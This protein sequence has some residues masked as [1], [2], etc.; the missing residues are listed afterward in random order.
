MFCP[1]CGNE[2]PDGST[3][4]ENCGVKLIQPEIN[5]L[6]DSLEGVQHPS[7]G[8]WLCNDGKY[9]WF[10]ELNMW[11]NPAIFFSVLRVF[12]M[13]AVILLVFFSVISHK[14]FY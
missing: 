12:G 7:P 4:C 14:S 2:I 13:T 10:Y 9:R 1:N 6:D 8:I 5:E 11:K 3:S